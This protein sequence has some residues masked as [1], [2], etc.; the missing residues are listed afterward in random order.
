MTVGA[1]GAMAITTDG[2]LW[3]WG[4]SHRQFPIKVDCVHDNFKVLG[5]IL[6]LNINFC[7]IY[8]DQI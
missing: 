7:T 8:L 6:S 4:D 2:E 1:T 3:S 5:N